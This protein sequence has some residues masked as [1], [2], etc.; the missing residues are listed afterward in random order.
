MEKV[1]VLFVCMGN[2]CRS[3]T[4]EGVFTKL[5]KE[6]NLEP[7][8][9]IDSAGTHAHHVGEAPDLRAQRAALD[10]GIMLSHLRARRVVMGD[11][12][13]FDYILAMDDENH[14]ILMNACP[15]HHK[16]KISYFL[17]FAPQLNQR[18]VPDPYFGG[19]F[20]FERVLDMVE[21][22]AEGFLAHLQDTKRIG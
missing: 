8:F 20:G 9:A 16:H 17:D 15:V 18:E 3:P 10:R 12:D 21:A 11:F 14:G 7:H 6:R 2:I 19:Q 1:K 4:A 22:A 13:D 5:I